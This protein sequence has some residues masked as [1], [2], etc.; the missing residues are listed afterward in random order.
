MAGYSGYLLW[1][2]FLGLDSDQFP[3]RN[4]G[5]LGF[6]AWGT[7]VRH[8]I[9]FIQALALLLLLGQVTILFGNNI[10]ELSKLQLCYIICPLIFV[11]AGFFLTQIRTLKNLS[12]SNANISWLVALN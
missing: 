5:D 11:L 10:Y 9:N 1:H 12:V 4:Y 3:A 8:L 2:V 6:R 7:P